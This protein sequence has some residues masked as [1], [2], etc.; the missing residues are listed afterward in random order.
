MTRNF[1][2]KLL[3]L[4]LL[5][6]GLLLAESEAKLPENNLKRPYC[7]IAGERNSLTQY[8]FDCMLQIPSMRAKLEILDANKPEITMEHDVVFPLPDVPLGEFVESSEDLSAF[9]LG[10]G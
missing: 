3:I 5:M 10:E 7:V 6:P 8:V 2:K 4:S 1:M 9:F